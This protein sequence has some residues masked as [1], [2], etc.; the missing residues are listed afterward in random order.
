LT[1]TITLQQEEY[2]LKN[3]QYWIVSSKEAKE[4][5]Y[6]EDEHGARIPVTL[7]NFDIK[8]L[9]DIQTFQDIIENKI[10][11]NKNLSLDQV[12]VFVEAI[13]Y[14]LEYDDFLD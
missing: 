11:H 1:K 9:L 3:S 4:L 7:I 6:V 13:L 10:E 12:D 2:L 5:D 8:R 14:Y